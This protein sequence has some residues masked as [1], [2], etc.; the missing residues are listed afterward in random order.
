M[1][2]TKLPSATTKGSSRSIVTDYDKSRLYA[3]RSTYTVF[4]IAERA[5][6]IHRQSNVGANVF[7]I[8]M[9]RP[10]HLDELKDALDYVQVKHSKL[11]YA[12][13]TVIE[14][15]GVYAKLN[16]GLP[17]DIEEKEVEGDEEQLHQVMETFLRKP[18]LEHQMLT[19][20]LFAQDSCDLV[21]AV[22]N[23]AADIAASGM[24]VNDL[25]KRYL[26]LVEYPTRA[27]TSTEVAPIV[28][29]F[30]NIFPPSSRTSFLHW[31][32]IAASMREYTR[33][34]KA[35]LS[36]SPYR[37]TTDS[38]PASFFTLELSTEL[39]ASIERNAAHHGVN[40]VSGVASAVLLAAKAHLFKPSSEVSD[41]SQPINFDF[42]FNSD[43]RTV[44]FKPPVPV[45]T[46][47]VAEVQS[48]HCVPAGTHDTSRNVWEIAHDIYND[49]AGAV[50]SD[51]LFDVYH[52]APTAASVQHRNIKS[53]PAAPFI[54]QDASNVALDPYLITN[55]NINDIRIAETA[56]HG[57]CKLLLTKFQ[58]KLQL[59]FNFGTATVSASEV[60]TITDAA[61][62]LIRKAP[63]ES[64]NT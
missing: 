33:L 45:E 39:T 63:V 14:G 50:A 11:Q 36:Q 2:T 60:E 18:L 1:A 29:D 40:L 48:Y 27:P 8:R 3:D 32:G 28:D 15:G 4:T 57:Q 7:A 41:L 19:K 16:S 55:L 44:G 53:L 52:Y 59:S 10:L 21:V 54:F 31:R 34:T 49:F 24:L 22:S 9:Q 12:A 20:A 26:E 23:G 61:L 47:S 25:L 6:C 51:R 30:A 58:G 56:F 17:L 38:S 46:L 37:L 43:L 64:S 42:W 5:K 35:M 62:E 13:R